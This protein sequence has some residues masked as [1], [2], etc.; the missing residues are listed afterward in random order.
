MFK[1][2]E[3]ANVYPAIME[4]SRKEIDA[5]NEFMS[6]LKGT[7]VAV[8]TIRSGQQ[9]PYAD[10]VYESLIVCFQP[11]SKTTNAPL[12]R[13]IDIDEAKMLA[14]LFVHSF[15]EKSNDPNDWATPQLQFIRPEAN[16][17]GLV[18]GEY[19]TKQG[20]S[21]CWRVCIKAAYTG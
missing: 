15:I 10:H 11:N 9:G 20:R 5:T 16:P 14:K 13:V 1:L 6:E 2:Q 7:C 3:R 19:F 21:S 18:D 8:K 17:C 4:Q 12:P